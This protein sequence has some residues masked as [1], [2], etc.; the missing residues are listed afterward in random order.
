MSSSGS[1]C[2]VTS[3]ELESPV[4]KLRILNET[5]KQH[6]ILISTDVKINAPKFVEYSSVYDYDEKRYL[7]SKY[8][9]QGKF[10]NLCPVKRAR[11][12]LSNKPYIHIPI[13]ELSLVRSLENWANC[14]VR[15]HGRFLTVDGRHFLE[16]IGCKSKSSKIELDLSLLAKHIFD[17]SVIQ[18]FGELMVTNNHSCPII[19]VMFFRR[20]GKMDL[21]KFNSVV[22]KLKP[23]VPLFANT[24]KMKDS[25][26]LNDSVVDWDQN[27]QVP[28][29][30]FF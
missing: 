19:Q 8:H 3:A 14:N 22:E 11:M 5:K 29:D 4:C 18:V 7:T 24:S 16:N 21:A 20:F 1:K 6:S 15:V 17:N 25:S 26:L 9:H 23:Y 13:E 12:E 28:V 27:S 30:S 10:F 2:N